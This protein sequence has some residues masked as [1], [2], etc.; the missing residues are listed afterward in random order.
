[1]NFSILQPFLADAVEFGSP[2]LRKVANAL[3]TDIAGEEEAEASIDS[4]VHD[5]ENDSIDKEKDQIDKMLIPQMPEIAVEDKIE[6]EQETFG[7]AAETQTYLE[8]LL[9]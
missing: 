4:V 1:M 9:S 2:E 8:Y 7:K 6:E 5:R 3:A